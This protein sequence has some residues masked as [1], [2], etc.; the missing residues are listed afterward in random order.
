MVALVAS[1]RPDPVMVSVARE[2]ERRHGQLLP[3]ALAAPSL[4]GMHDDADFVLS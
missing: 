2:G 1:A 4:P 3:A